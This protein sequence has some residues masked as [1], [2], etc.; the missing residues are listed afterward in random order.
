MLR[1]YLA[2]VLVVCACVYT[3]EADHLGHT[4]TTNDNCT[5]VS[6]AACLGTE[7]NKTCQCTS[8]FKANG[9]TACVAVLGSQCTAPANCNSV[10]NS[11]CTNGVCKC[12]SLYKPVENVCNTVLNSQCTA[13]ENCSSVANSECTNLLCKCKSTYKPMVDHCMPV[14]GNTCSGDSCSVVTNAICN[15]TCKCSANYTQKVDVCIIGLGNPCADNAACTNVAH[16]ICENKICACMAGYN[17]KGTECVV[18]SSAGVLSVGIVAMATCFI[19]LLM[20]QKTLG[21]C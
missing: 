14:L 10:S 20:G 1:T 8:L 15:T 5:D 6:N 12:N 11:N 17:I 19:A 3:A 13:T 4:C 7:G 2:F 16:S 18:V 9:T 21:S